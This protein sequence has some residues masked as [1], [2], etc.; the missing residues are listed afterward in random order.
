MQKLIIASNN[1]H[2]IAEIKEILSP[3]Y[4]EILSLKEAGLSVE[5]EEDGET[6]EENALKKAEEIFRAAG[7]G[8]AVLSDDSGLMVDALSGAPGVRSARFAGEGHNNAANTAKLLQ[9]MADVPLPE[10]GCR[11]VSAV[12]L[13]QPGREPVVARGVVEGR[14]LHVLRGWNGFGYDSVFYYAP[15][16]R[17][18]AELTAWEKNRISHRK[19]A[20]EALRKILSEE[21]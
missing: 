19:N 12:A 16:K 17:S 9:A 18:F 3:F 11:F 21:A 5:V 7:G 6:F 20:L 8:A 13:V 1:A 10:R 4:S 15:L 2:K 14:V